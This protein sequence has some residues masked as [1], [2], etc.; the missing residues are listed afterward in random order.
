MPVSDDTR[1]QRR[2]FPNEANAGTG[3]LGLIMLSRAR[4]DYNTPWPTHLRHQS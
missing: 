1:L 4:A 3:N 2:R